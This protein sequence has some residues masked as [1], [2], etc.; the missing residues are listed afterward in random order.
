MATYLIDEKIKIVRQ[1]G[2]TADLE[3][4][5]SGLDIATYD[6]YFGVFDRHGVK[7][8]DKKLTDWVKDDQT[9]TNCF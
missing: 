7:I 2:D 3:F 5:I 9:I 1:E 6:I 4:L 8:I